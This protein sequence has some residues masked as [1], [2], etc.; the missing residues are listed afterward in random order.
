MKKNTI[1][2]DKLYLNSNEIIIQQKFEDNK[3][4][5]KIQWALCI[6]D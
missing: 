5:D 2:Y 3:D 1:K 6:I 4:E